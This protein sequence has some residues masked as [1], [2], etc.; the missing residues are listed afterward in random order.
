[1][2]ISFLCLSQG[3]TSITVWGLP[4][5]L[6]FEMPH[7]IVLRQVTGSNQPVNAHYQEETETR[8]SHG[9]RGKPFYDINLPLLFSEKLPDWGIEYLQERTG[10]DTHSLKRNDNRIS[11]HETILTSVHQEVIT[12]SRPSLLGTWPTPVEW[13][14]IIITSSYSPSYPKLYCIL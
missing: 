5:R 14:Q 1:M 13:L 8:P 4:E 6:N 11:E 10:C 3:F 2:R 9:E 12:M 7:V